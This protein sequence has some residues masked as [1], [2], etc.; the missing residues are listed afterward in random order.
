MPDFSLRSRM[1]GKNVIPF[2]KNHSSVSAHSCPFRQ[3]RRHF[4][5]RQ[6]V[7]LT[8]AASLCSS[9]SGSLASRVRG[10]LSGCI[11]LFPQQVETAHDSYFFRFFLLSGD[12]LCFCISFLLSGNFYFMQQKRPLSRSFCYFSFRQIRM[13]SSVQCPKH[14]SDLL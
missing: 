14:L 4:S 3:L 10:R 2:C 6:S 5:Q 11:L 7:S 13:R 1:T 9:K 8:F 12:G